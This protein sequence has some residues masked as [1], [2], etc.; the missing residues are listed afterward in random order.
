MAGVALVLPLVSKRTVWFI[1]LS[2]M[3]IGLLV[4]GFFICG[5]K[6]V[7]WDGLG[8]LIVGLFSTIIA[9]A[10]MVTGLVRVVSSGGGKR[11]VNL[12]RVILG[13]ALSYG[14]AFVAILGLILWAK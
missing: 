11:P 14:L 6:A 9:A 13:A 2:L 3:A 8:C 5:G 12:Q 7:G 1:V 10:G 4:L